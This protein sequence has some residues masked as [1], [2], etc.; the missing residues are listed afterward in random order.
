MNDWHALQRVDFDELLQKQI[1]VYRDMAEVYLEQRDQIPAGRLVEIQYEELER[2]KV[3]QIRRIYDNLG[4]DGYG[5]FEPRLME[6]VASIEGFQKNPSHVS[7]QVIAAVN[8]YVPFLVS[9]YGY[10]SRTVS[11]GA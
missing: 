3:G 2:D 11:G 1:E 8:E 7:D 4:L 10:P 6:Y 5:E 9:E